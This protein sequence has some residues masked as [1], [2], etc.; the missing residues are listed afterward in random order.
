MPPLEL[1]LD[2]AMSAFSLRHGGALEILSFLILVHPPRGR[3]TAPFH[4]ATH[5]AS[6]RASAPVMNDAPLPDRNQITSAISR[7]SAHLPNACSSSRCF[8]Y[9]FEG[10]GAGHD[11]DSVLHNVSLELRKS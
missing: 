8:L 6:A 7:G 2:F 11:C 5:P 4:L 9:F 1:V 10:S 3:R